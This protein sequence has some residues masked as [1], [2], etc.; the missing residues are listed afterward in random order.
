MWRRG[1]EGPRTIP[2]D[3]VADQ[4]WNAILNNQ[5]YVFTHPTIKSNIQKRTDDLIQERTPEEM[6]LYTD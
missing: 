3:A 4:T 2:P 6:P 5:F 1:Y